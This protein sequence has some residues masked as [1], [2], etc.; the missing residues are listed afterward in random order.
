MWLP[1][2]VLY[3]ASTCEG[4]RFQITNARWNQCCE[5]ESG[6]AW[7]RIRFEDWIRIRIK[8]ISWIGGQMTSQ[9]VWNM[10]LFEHFFEVLSLYLEAGIRIRIRIKVMRI[11]NT[12]WNIDKSFTK[13]NYFLVVSPLFWLSFVVGP[14]RSPSG[15]AG[16]AVLLTRQLSSH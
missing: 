1:A 9:N 6:S 2:P 5:S 12:G 8:V 14:R 7:F 11:R 10:S 15:W 13:H 16:D 3:M 4:E